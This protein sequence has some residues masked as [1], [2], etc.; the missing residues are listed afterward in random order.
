[1]TR[2]LLLAALIA[3]LGCTK[4]QPPPAPPAAKE[5][6]APA[7]ADEAAAAGAA[8]A[9]E[10]ELKPV[11]ADFAGPP[12]PLA[13]K[14]CG[15]LYD[16]PGA[17]RAQCC[18][19]KPAATLGGECVRIVSAA[20]RSGGVQLDAKG[21][22]ACAAAQ[23]AAHAGC[24]WVGQFHPPTPA[25]C[26][27][28]FSGH[29]KANEVCRSSL[30]CSD[31]L[32]CQGAGPMDAGRCGP[33]RGDG[34]ACLTAVDPLAVYARQDLDARHPECAGY[35][36]HR[37]CEPITAAGA[38]CSIAPECPRGQH[39]DGKKCAQGEFAAL[40]QACAGGTCAPGARCLQGKCAEPKADGA[41]CTDDL[42]C[43]GGCAPATRRCGMR[44][45]LF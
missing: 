38:A 31:G 18:G 19:G 29:R 6:S 44:C 15:A 22:D 2:R 35:C 42:E 43:R 10:E 45:D 39:C 1:M 4:K 40:G 25:A 26:G 5:A 32:R 12:A 21:V 27:G 7:G 41:S 30:E 20:L 37:R 28:L 23:E 17:R 34:Q 11:Y 33:P 24:S 16:L 9:A 3:S 8:V 36:G 13:Q 14:L